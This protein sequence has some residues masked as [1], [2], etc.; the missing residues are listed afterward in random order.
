MVEE[1]GHRHRRHVELAGDVQLDAAVG[2]HARR[3]QLRQQVGEGEARVLELEH[4]LAEGAARLGVVDGRLE[5]GLAGRHRAHR[6]REALLHQLGHQQLPAAVLLAEQVLDRHAHV[7]EEQ[8]RGVLRLVA[9]LLQVAALAVAGGRRVD[10]QQRHAARLQRRLGLHHQQRQVAD[11]AVGDEG[12][13]AVDDVVVAVPLSARADAAQ[14]AARSRL[15]HAD[16]G[17]DLARSHLRQPGAASAPRCRGGSDR[18]PRSTNA[19]PRPVRARRRGPA[20]RW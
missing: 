9:G 8:L 19:G 11:D 20:P 10:Q 4:R 16:R 1:L 2:E 14:V 6:D 5:R 15:G 13:R 17:D 7:L 18:A 3:L 12:L